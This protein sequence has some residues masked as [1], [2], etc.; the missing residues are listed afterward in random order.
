[1]GYLRLAGVGVL[2]VT[3]L[4]T[5]Q[6]LAAQQKLP[7]IQ[8]KQVVATVN[9]EPITLDDFN[10]ELVGLQQGADQNKPVPE[11]DRLD[12]LARLVNTRLLI[13]EARRM[14]LDELPEVKNMIDV[15]SRIALREDLMRRYTKDLRVEDKEVETAYKEAVKEWRMSSV[16]FEREDDAK[17]MQQALAA[18]KDFLELG[19]QLA[20]EKTA[21]ALEESKDLKAKDVEPAIASVVEKM[22]VGSVSPIVPF[23]SGFAILRLEDTRYP[24]DPEALAQAKREAFKKKTLQ[25]LTAKRDELVKKY[26]KVH[27]DVLSQIDYESKDPGFD[28][29]LKDKRVV[30]EIKGEDAITVGEMTVTLKQQFY[31]GVQQAIESKRLN[32]KKASTLDD[33]VYKRV[34]RKEALRLGLD[35]TDAYRSKVKNYAQSVVFG[36][37]VEK[38]V[39]PDVKVKDEEART[40]YQQHLKEFELPEVVKMNGLVFGDRSNAE[41]A[42]EE[43]RKGTEFQWLSAHAEGQVDQGAEGVLTFDGK[44]LTTRDLPAGLQKAI[45]GARAGDLRLYASPDGL[46]YALAVQDVVSSKPQ[47]YEDVQDIVSRRLYNDKVRQAIED[48]AQKVRAVSDVKIYLNS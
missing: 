3:S 22:A 11:K 32:A 13:Q 45:S 47:P 7:V 37:F 21:K 4:L 35:K 19:R 46:F 15:F 20:A 29:L 38:A 26:A 33:L 28:A 31:H 48:Y 24:E 8:G 41:K 39:S 18:G 2:V 44:P 40:Y 34:F 36:T 42:I 10:R 25:I 6:G 9:R 23:K 30:A 27:A 12:L 1:M 5:S 17:K 43:L 16:F 14:G